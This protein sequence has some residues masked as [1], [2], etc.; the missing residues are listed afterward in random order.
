MTLFFLTDYTSTLIFLCVPLRFCG[1]KFVVV[2]FL[3]NSLFIF[4]VVI[5]HLREIIY[6]PIAASKSFIKSSASSIPTLNL[7]KLSFKPFFKRSSLGILAW[8]ILAG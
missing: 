8:V 4:Q 5:V 6:Y 2:L 7:I 1:K 3:T